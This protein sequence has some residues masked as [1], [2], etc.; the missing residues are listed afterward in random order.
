MSAVRSG[1]AGKGNQVI[2]NLDL[3]GKRSEVEAIVPGANPNV[4]VTLPADSL[5]CLW[6]HTLP[7]S[8]QVLRE[9]LSVWIVMG[10]PNSSKP[11]G[12]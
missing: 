3:A 11:G 9:G 10:H 7:G 8:L 2:K 5:V 12:L 6:P 1:H 4:P